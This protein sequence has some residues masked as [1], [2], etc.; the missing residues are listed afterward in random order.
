MG[1]GFKT[2]SYLED[3]IR[4]TCIPIFNTHIHKLKNSLLLNGQFRAEDKKKRFW[5][6][7]VFIL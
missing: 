7:S 5:L 3:F 6:F 1:V 4:Y 2:H